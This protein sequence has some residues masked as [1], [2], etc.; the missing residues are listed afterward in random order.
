[1]LLFSGGLIGPPGTPRNYSGSLDGKPV[2]IGCSDVDFH[3]PPE[4]VPETTAVLTELGAAV[5][6]KTYPSRDYTIIPDEIEQARR[7][8][9]AVGSEK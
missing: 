4:R 1:M 3:I 9:P 7:V 8:L 5:T 2:F 6:E